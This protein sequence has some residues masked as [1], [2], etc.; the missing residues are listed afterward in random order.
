MDGDLVKVAFFGRVMK[1]NVVDDTVDVKK[2]GG[3]NEV[4]KI[5]S[6]L[7]IPAK[8]FVVGDCVECNYRGKGKWY[9]GK[10]L[11]VI[12]SNDDILYDILYDDGDQEPNLSCSHVRIH[13]PDKERSIDVEMLK[14]GMSLESRYKG[15]SK[16]Y[17]AKIRAIHEDSTVDLHY[18]GKYTQQ[19]RCFYPRFSPLLMNHHHHHHHHHHQRKYLVVIKLHLELSLIAIPNSHTIQQNPNLILNLNPQPDGEHESHVHVGML[20]RVLSGLSIASELGVLH[21]DDQSPP[22]LKSTL[23]TE[24]G[25]QPQPSVAA[26]GSSSSV[27]KTPQSH[28][29]FADGQRIECYYQ[30]SKSWIEGVISGYHEDDGTYNLDFNVSTDVDKNNTAMT[31]QP[32]HSV[33]ERTATSSG[34]EIVP[35]PRLDKK[36]LYHVPISRIRKITFQ[37]GDR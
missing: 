6:S 36:H 25:N 16:Y 1:T 5:P 28:Q 7:L 2:A 3:N 19:K 15:K 22:R 12:E 30:T 26:G 33:S 29:M 17:A 9:T 37:E 24:I 21:N 35:P 20:R 32:I 23:S 27:A 11:K 8:L 18:Y 31:D 4:I 10:I 34:Q 13:V 14:V